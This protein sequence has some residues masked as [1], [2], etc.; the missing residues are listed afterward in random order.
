MIQQESK[1]ILAQVQTILS[2]YDFPLSLRQIYY[3]L[4]SRQIIENV[5]NEYRK[6][7][8][9]TVIGRD[10]G[11]LDEEKFTDRLRQIQQ[12]DTWTD[13]V[14]FMQT[15]KRAYRKD[16]W[17]QQPDYIEIWIEKDALRGVVEPVT[18]KYGVPLLVVRGQ[19]SRTAI[20]D[21]YQR[22]IEEDKYCY[23]YYFGDFDPSGITIYESLLNRLS[24]F[25]G[26]KLDITFERVA[27]TQEQIDKY[28]LPPAPAKKTDPNTS[29]FIHEHGDNVVELDALPPE[30][31][32][33]LVQETINQHIDTDIWNETA[34][35]EAQETEELQEFIAGRE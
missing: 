5:E 6:L 29:R 23:L 22:Y 33:E 34:S 1:A 28:N 27:L 8:R 15:V 35:I 25:N 16:Y 11:I 20:Y 12:P 2:E 19:V 31:L 7:S 18:N 13:L 21:A 26:G 9:L 3:Q 14:D 24:G 17:I 4:V 32:I 10:E 30:E